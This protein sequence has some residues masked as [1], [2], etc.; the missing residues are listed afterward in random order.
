MEENHNRKRLRNDF[1]RVNVQVQA[2][3][4]AIDLNIA[5]EWIALNAHWWI[6]ISFQGVIPR[7]LSQRSLIEKINK[8]N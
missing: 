5:T 4:A 1:W 6:V 2:I 3:L 8:I 7:L